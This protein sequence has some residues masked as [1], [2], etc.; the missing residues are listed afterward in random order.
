VAAQGL[1]IGEIGQISFT[2]TA[3]GQWYARARYRG[4]NGEVKHRR[5]SGDTRKSAERDLRQRC[6]ESDLYTQGDGG[7]LTP[8]SKVSELFEFWLAEGRFLGSPAPQTLDKYEREGKQFILPALGGMRLRELTTSRADNF[9]K[10][11][12]Q[13]RSLSTARRMKAN[14]SSMCSLAVRHDAM[15]TNVVRDTAKLP[16]P[17]KEIFA[18][19]IEDVAV[20]RQAMADDRTNPLRTG[21]RPDKQLEQIIEV[22]LG[23]SA[24][25]G[26]V[27]AIRKQDVDLSRSPATVLIA[28]TIIESRSTGLI[29]QP[30]SKRERQHRIITLPD[31]ARRA[32]EERLLVIAGQPR[33]AL[34]FSTRNGTPHGL[35]NIG[36]RW[37]KFRAAHPE[38][39]VA[40]FEKAVPYTF[41][42]TVATV[43]SQAEGMGL[44]T[45]LLGHESGT[46]TKEHY[47]MPTERVNPE[48]AVLLERV[49]G[50]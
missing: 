35:S 15:T 29:R 40:G 5:G 1:A 30:H 19:A 18:L 43:V 50:R 12:R 36:R 3:A 17:R 16:K 25:P 21:R 20:I 27:L 10:N 13:T 33:D 4:H 38:L 31:F 9:L 45:E 46:T 28:G 11:V 47:V 49:F 39:D 34:I 48:T 44:A 26:E 22:I 6:A 23:T 14:L 41:R 42:K 8:D 7:V 32:I 37:R 24:R 2:E